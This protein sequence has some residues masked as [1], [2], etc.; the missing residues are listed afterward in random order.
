MLKDPPLTRRRLVP[1]K[2]RC[3]ERNAKGRKTEGCYP[4]LKR[5]FRLTSFEVS[6]LAWGPPWGMAHE[7][8]LPTKPPGS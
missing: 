5:Q 1:R 6:S 4:S 7:G 8:C 2:Q 3:F